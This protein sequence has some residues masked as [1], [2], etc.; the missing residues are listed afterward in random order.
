MALKADYDAQACSLARALE[1]LGERWTLL[2]VRDAFYGVRRFGDFLEHLDVP[3]AVLTARL[4]VL[5]EAGVLQRRPYSPGRDEYVLT[6]AGEQ[7]WPA[8]YALSTWAGVHLA[9][10]GPARLFVHASCGE[11]LEPS[12]RCPACGNVPP[13]PELEVH[14]GPGAEHPPRADSV[15]RALRTPRRLLQPLRPDNEK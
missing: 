7:L 2:V 1:V 6:P 11:G 10:H 12:G 15:S 3:R 4:R 5:T 8:L 13:A 14:P 9:E